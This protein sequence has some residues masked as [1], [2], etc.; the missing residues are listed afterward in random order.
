MKGE[1][2]NSLVLMVQSSHK[3]FCYYSIS[4]M[5]VKKFQDIYGEVLW[6]NSKLAIEVYFIENGLAKNIKTIPMESFMGSCYIDIKKEDVDIFVKFGV[7]LPKNKFVQLA[8]SNV[9]TTPPSSKSSR[10]FLC[11]VDISETHGFDLKEESINR[12]KYEYPKL[13]FGDESRYD[14]FMDKYVDRLKGKY[15]LTSS[16]GGS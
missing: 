13:I 12:K 8:V 5:N 6:K 10:D 14:E 2:E 7:I 4:P 1:E 11:F 3:I 16:R 9:V 15:R